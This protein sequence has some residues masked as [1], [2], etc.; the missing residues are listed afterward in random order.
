MLQIHSHLQD[1]QM[2]NPIP[3]G[4]LTPAQHEIMQH[5]WNTGRAGL[6]VGETWQLVSETRDVARTTTLKL[7]ERLEQRGWLIR[8]EAR[9]NQKGS[10]MRF[11]ATI[12]P[13]R[14]RAMMLQQFVADYYDGSAAELA[15]SLLKFK[16]L[17][18]GDMGE[19]KQLLVERLS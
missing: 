2:N 1:L 3:E 15:K 19:L 11:A 9:A 17:T 16:C 6:S 4:N 12:G 10:A 5:V 18:R 13:R 7:I 8:Q 14:A